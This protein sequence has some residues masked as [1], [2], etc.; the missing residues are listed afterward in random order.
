MH[1]VGPARC[2]PGAPLDCRRRRQRQLDLATVWPDGNFHTI[3]AKR[4]AEEVRK[5][6]DGAVEIT[7]QGRRLS[8][9]SRGRS[10]C[11][12]CATGW[13]RSPTSS[14]SSRSAT[15]R[16]S[17]P[18]ASRSWSAPIEE[19]KVL[20]KYLRP[21]YEKI[22][23]EEQSEN[24]LHGAVADAVPAPQGEGRHARR[25]EGHQDPRAGQERAG[26]VQRR[27]AWRRC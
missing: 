23:A 22:A 13:C 4:F 14:T 18:R 19:L 26:H 6:T 25:A 1:G 24:P 16:C 7:V 27:S 3:N 15:S 5:A 10:S 11:A 2:S 20:H 21:E 8:S 9:A 17:A 12:R